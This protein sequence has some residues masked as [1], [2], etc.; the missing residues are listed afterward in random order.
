[1]DKC[2]IC[3]RECGVNRNISG[4]FCGEKKLKIAH[5]MFHHWE[6]PPI[7]GD[8]NFVGS[9]AIFFSGCNLK[10][11]YC[12][13]WEISNNKEGKA[14]SVSELVDIFKKLECAGANNINLVTPTHFAEEIIEALKIYKPQVPVVWNTSGYEKPETIEKLRGLVDIFLTDIRYFSPETAKKYSLAEDYF[15]CA[16]CAV[17]KMREVVGQDK[18]NG[19][20][21]KKGV[22]IRLL[23]LPNMTTEAIKILDWIN[24]N[25]GNK[26]I[27]SIMNQ[28]F[29]CYKAKDYPEI[30]RK[31]REIEYSRVVHYAEKLGFNNAYTQEKTSAS[32]EYVPNFK[33]KKPF[34]F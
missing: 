9:G 23:V 26:T 29:P 7:S 18:F 34:K 3:P 19:G 2:C 8:E 6:E 15:D 14:V 33:G 30:N 1:M 28:Y 12:Q 24:D 10:C 16:S 20:L 17:K 25:L 4:G 13:N 11:V 22:I 21:M 31:V 32:Q 27:V 5:I